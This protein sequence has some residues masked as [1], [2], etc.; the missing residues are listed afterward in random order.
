MIYSQMCKEILS[1]INQGKSIKTLPHKV[2][3]LMEIEKNAQSYQ[4]WTLLYV[5]C[6]CVLRAS[7][8][9]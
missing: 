8:V 3:D 2:S 1:K 7:K 5:Y 6:V 9:L 4:L